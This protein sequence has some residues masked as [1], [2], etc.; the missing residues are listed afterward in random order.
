M[1]TPAICCAPVH[2]DRLL[3]GPR[4]QLPSQR[5]ALTS[6]PVT[7]PTLPSAL[8][9]SPTQLPPHLPRASVGSPARPPSLPVVDPTLSRPGHPA[10]SPGLRPQKPLSRDGQQ[11]GSAPGQGPG[12]L[13]TALP[14]RCHSA[15][16]F[17]PAPPAAA[18]FLP[19]ILSIGSSRAFCPT[20]APVT[21]QRREGTRCVSP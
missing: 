13:Y 6:T 21:H 4:D 7:A 16:S 3:P 8:G 19:R 12:A 5:C 9:V 17:R 10:L 18:S 2:P 15:T 14:P 1:P 20:A 11:A